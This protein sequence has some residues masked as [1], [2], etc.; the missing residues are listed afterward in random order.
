MLVRATDGLILPRRA[1]SWNIE[2]GPRS[3]GLVILFF[4]FL[5][6]LIKL[7]CVNESAYLGIVGGKLWGVSEATALA[8]EGSVQA[9]LRMY[10][11]SYVGMCMI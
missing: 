8:G 7:V 2:L 6:K 5:K 9:I 10:V 1:C 3:A 4:F 11:R